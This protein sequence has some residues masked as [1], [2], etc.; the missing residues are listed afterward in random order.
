MLTYCF[1]PVHLPFEAACPALITCIDACE[2]LVG[3]AE[4]RGWETLDGMGRMD[5]GGPDFLSFQN[6]SPVQSNG[7][8]TIPI[9]C[10][11][12]GQAL[13]ALDGDLT[14]SRLGPALCHLAVRSS[15]ARKSAHSLVN[16]RVFQ[17]VSEVAVSE[18]LD[19]LAQR[20]TIAV[21]GGM[22]A[23]EADPTRASP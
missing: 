18:F 1:V 21:D 22:P 10:S 7:Y 19:Q 16:N 5:G 6:G 12:G 4:Q 23:S 15:T 13:I 20:M 3:G 2:E 14:L 9:T 17:M 8:I 11:S